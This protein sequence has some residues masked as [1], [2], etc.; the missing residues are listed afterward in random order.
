MVTIFRQT[1]AKF[2]ICMLRNTFKRDFH[3]SGWIAGVRY[4]SYLFTQIISHTFFSLT[5][6]HM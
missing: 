5:F 1:I 4:R 3:L 6:F 2:T